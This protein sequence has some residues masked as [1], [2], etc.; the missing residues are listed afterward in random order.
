M[1]IAKKSSMKSPKQ[2]VTIGLAL[3]V[4]VG[5]LGLETVFA[6]PDQLKFTA[7]LLLEVPVGQSVDVTDAGETKTVKKDSAYQLKM[8]DTVAVKS[9]SDVTIH[10]TDRGLVRLSD[11]AILSVAVLDNQ[12]DN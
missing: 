4:F 12:S 8:G 7:D 11:N 2:L 6:G 3:V 1:V 9:G 5:S 10:F